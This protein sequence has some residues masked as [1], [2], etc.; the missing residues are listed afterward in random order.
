M[1]FRAGSYD[2]IS[3]FALSCCTCALRTPEERLPLGA[4]KEEFGRMISKSSSLGDRTKFWSTTSA[5][6]R[7]G[8]GTCDNP[9]ILGRVLDSAFVQVRVRL[10]CSDGLIYTGHHTLL[11]HASPPR[12]AAAELSYNP[13]GKIFLKNHPAKFFLRGPWG[14]TL[15]RRKKRVGA[16]E[17]W[18]QNPNKKISNLVHHPAEFLS[19]F[20]CLQSFYSSGLRPYETKNMPLWDQNY[21]SWFAS[22]PYLFSQ[23]T[24]LFAA[25]ALQQ[26]KSVMQ[27]KWRLVHF[28]L[29]HPWSHHRR[30]GGVAALL[31]LLAFTLLVM[32]GRRLGGAHSRVPRFMFLAVTVYHA[33]RRRGL[34]WWNRS[35][36]WCEALGQNCGI[37]VLLNWYKRLLCACINVHICTHAC[38]SKHSENHHHDVMFK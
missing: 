19:N 35:H 16:L 29:M 9:C 3:I 36:P 25:S 37:C 28:I 33:L 8:A 32:S 13:P 15:L 26:D 4:P 24:S 7:G 5:G 11:C 38:W 6:A 23:F 2:C 18:M 34:W 12:A 30:H 10:N 17:V 31:L 1:D 22:C 21:W 20:V 27:Q 14:K